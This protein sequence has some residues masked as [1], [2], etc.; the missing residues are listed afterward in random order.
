MVDFYPHTATSQ[1][2]KV[3][4]M[5]F[6]VNSLE[7]N[8]CY[9]C[10]S[11]VLVAHKRALQK[12]L[13]W[14]TTSI[15]LYIP[16]NFYPIMNTLYLGDRTESTIFGGVL[17]LWSH[18]SYPIAIIIFVASVMV[19]VVK[20]MALATLC[21]FA[22]DSKRVDYGNHHKILRM[23]ELVGRWSMVDIYVV[24]VLVALIQMGNIMTI[25]PGEASIAFAAMVVTTMIAAM[26]FDPKLIWQKI[27]SQSNGDP[28][29]K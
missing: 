26:S 27:D 8:Y 24:T 4:S 14:L 7:T 19:P 10:D 18:G 20:I 21:Y 5:C 1:Q 9:H 6:R 2:K 16:A 28:S 29:V 22:M 12:T 13:A 23:T 15:I 25:N 3:C 17:T 11:K